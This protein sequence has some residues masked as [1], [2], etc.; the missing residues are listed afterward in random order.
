MA[1]ELLEPEDA[2]QIDEEPKY[3]PYTV[4]SDM[5]AIGV[6]LYEMCALRKPFVAEN[7]DDLYKKVRKA[8]PATIK[9]VSR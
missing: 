6:I 8:K 9:T 1:P 4:K 5:W 7:E 2:D 3:H